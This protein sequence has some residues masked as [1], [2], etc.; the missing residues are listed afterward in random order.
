MRRGDVDAVAGRGLLTAGETASYESD[1]AVDARFEDLYPYVAR[2]ASKEAQGYIVGRGAVGI[3]ADYVVESGVSTEQ[4]PELRRAGD[5]VRVGAI[6]QMT[7]S[8]APRRNL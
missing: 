7:G 6:R 4:R 5:D 1:G 2:N 8:G 3:L